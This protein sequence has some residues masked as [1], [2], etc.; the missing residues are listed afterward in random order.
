MKLFHKNQAKFIFKLNHAGLNL[1]NKYE[2]DEKILIYNLSSE[3]YTI[4]AVA[5]TSC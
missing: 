4:R 2:I 3:R 5:I 1:E